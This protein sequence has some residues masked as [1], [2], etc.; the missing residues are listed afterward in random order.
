MTLEELDT[1]EECMASP[2]LDKWEENF[3]QNLYDEYQDKPLILSQ[4]IKLN[5]IA[6]R[7]EI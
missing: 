6:D 3:L 5:E 1:I 2:D 7:L 4:I